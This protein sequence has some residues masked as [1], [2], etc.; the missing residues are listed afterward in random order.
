MYGTKPNFGIPG[1]D[2]PAIMKV[3][4]ST[5]GF[6]LGAATA[7]WSLPAGAISVGVLGLMLGNGKQGALIGAGLGAGYAVLTGTRVAQK[8]SQV[9]QAVVAA[10]RSSPEDRQHAREGATAIRRQ[11]QRSSTTPHPQ[12]PHGHGVDI[13]EWNKQVAAG[14][15]KYQ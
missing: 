7:V 4:P 12:P 8:V 2:N 14:T 9:Q 11:L 5:A 1:V 3:K 10:N 6:L 13:E 15:Q